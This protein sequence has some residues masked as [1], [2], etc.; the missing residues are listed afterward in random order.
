M[1]NCV[2]CWATSYFRDLQIPLVLAVATAPVPIITPIVHSTAL[3]AVKPDLRYLWSI[4]LIGSVINNQELLAARASFKL[5]VVGAR[6]GR[7]CGRRAKRSGS[8]TANTT[9]GVRIGIHRWRQRGGLQSQKKAE[10]SEKGRVC[11]LRASTIP[12]LASIRH[13]RL[14][15][16]RPRGRRG[17]LTPYPRPRGP[18][19]PSRGPP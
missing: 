12:L 8:R 4:A 5:G 2:A 9:I 6:G 16:R 18:R 15:G 7:D 13:S 19:G 17:E 11:A 10:K 14:P 3:S 1:S